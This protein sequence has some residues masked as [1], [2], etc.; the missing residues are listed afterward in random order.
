MSNTLKI[1]KNIPAPSAAKY[2]FE[3]MNVGD[4][5]LVPASVAKPSAVRVAASNYSLR[6]EGFFFRTRQESRGTRV[7]RIKAEAV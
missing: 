5:V 7:W 4:S 3:D 1:E 6:H 2:P